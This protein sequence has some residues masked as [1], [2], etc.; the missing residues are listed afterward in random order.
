MATNK[1]KSQ[2]GDTWITTAAGEVV[3]V[4][5][6]GVG[7]STSLGNVRAETDP[8]KHKDQKTNIQ[9]L[10]TQQVE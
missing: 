9:N 4:I 3:G 7:R 6:Q 8:L 2:P 1:R 10:L 5:P